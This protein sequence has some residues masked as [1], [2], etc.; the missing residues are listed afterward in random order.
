MKHITSKAILFIIIVFMP[1][2][3]CGNNIQQ[4]SNTQNSYVIDN[5]DNNNLIG[6]K[7]LY[8]NTN[9]YGI[10]IYF[11]SDNW[12]KVYAFKRN[13]NRHNANDHYYVL[14]EE[15]LCTYTID[16]QNNK[17][18]TIWLTEGEWKEPLGSFTVI[19]NSMG[20]MNKKQTMS[21]TLKKVDY[22]IDCIQ[23]E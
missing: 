18:G 1:V 20:F 12:V 6:T 21:W 2:I 13:D 23:I 22:T 15:H 19:G 3:M 17:N 5:N 4:L 8:E 9:D 16:K 7:W 14:E 11:V 10:Y